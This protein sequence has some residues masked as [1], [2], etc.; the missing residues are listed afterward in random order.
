MIAVIGAENRV[1]GRHAEPMRAL[2]NPLAPGAQEVAITIEHGDRMRAP[3]EHI[4]LIPAID[5]HRRHLIEIPAIRQS[6]PIGDQS[7]FE[8]T[9]AQD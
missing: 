1:I 4:D 2:E 3:A 6:C 9:A 8:V 5:G 7:I